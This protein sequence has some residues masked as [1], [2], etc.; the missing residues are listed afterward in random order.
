MKNYQLHRKYQ[1]D[2]KTSNVPVFTFHCCFFNDP[3]ET[4]E[5]AVVIFGLRPDM[6]IKIASCC[7]EKRS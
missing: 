3:L 5:K 7:P 2:G 6:E 1:L 4:S